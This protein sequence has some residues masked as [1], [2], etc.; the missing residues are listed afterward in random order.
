MELN[1]HHFSPEPIFIGF[2][3]SIVCEPCPEHSKNTDTISQKSDFINI[4][5]Q[6]Y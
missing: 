6:Q 1:N 2:W 4:S 5:T 3:L